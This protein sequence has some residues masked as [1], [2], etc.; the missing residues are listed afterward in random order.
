V[1]DVNSGK[2][3]IAC[4]PSRLTPMQKPPVG[5]IGMTQRERERGERGERNE[6][7]R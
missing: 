1:S 7:K 3:R 2:N 6:H 5:S 4:H